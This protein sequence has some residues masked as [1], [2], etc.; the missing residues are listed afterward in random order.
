MARYENIKLPVCKITYRFFVKFINFYIPKINQIKIYPVNTADKVYG[1][2]IF[3][4]VLFKS[5]YPSL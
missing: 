1:T 4:K 2:E 3:I 5:S